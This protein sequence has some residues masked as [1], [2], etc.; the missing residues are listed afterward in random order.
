MDARS[1]YDSR[2]DFHL[3]DVRE[4]EEWELGHVEG[5]IHVPLQEL[6]RSIGEL[7]RDKPILCVCMVGV[8]SQYAAT[9]LASAGF[10]TE[11]LDGGLASWQ[12]AGLPLV[13]PDGSEARVWM[14]G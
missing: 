4:P 3:L 2:D 1:A 7:P 5:S 13:G 14:P 11:N 6:E 10:E 9:A 12:A 8:R